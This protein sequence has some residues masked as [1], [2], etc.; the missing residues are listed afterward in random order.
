MTVISAAKTLGDL[1]AWKITNMEMQKLL[2]IAQVL[3]LGRNGKPMFSEQFEAWQFGPVLKSL[4]HTAK[5]NG[6]NKMRPLS[7]APFSSTSTEY[8][9]ICEAVQ[10]THGMRGRDLVDFAHRH[11]GAWKRSYQPDKRNIKIANSALIEE[12]QRDFAPSKAAM[13]WAEEMAAANEAA[14][15]KCLD[16]KDERAFRARLQEASRS[17]RRGV[18]RLVPTPSKCS[19]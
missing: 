19:A 17:V 9:A 7:A 3:H 4:Y 8:A 6:G 18:G 15:A 2:Y 1:T 5:S 16:D 12:Y 11:G 14:P 10:L 13:D